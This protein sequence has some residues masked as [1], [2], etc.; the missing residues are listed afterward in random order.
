[1]DNA[2][3]KDFAPQTVDKVERLIDLLDEFVE[4][5]GLKNKLA[6]YTTVCR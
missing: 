4:H 5:H 6:L 2:L 3:L 1:M